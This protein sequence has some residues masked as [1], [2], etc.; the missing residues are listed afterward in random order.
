MS[1]P[2]PRKELRL[3][4]SSTFRD[5]MP[6]R[7]QLV[8]K[9]FPRIRK[10]CRARGVEFTEI[11]LRWGITEEESRSGRTI[12]ICLEEIDRCRPY[13]IGII[14]SRYGWV[15]G[16]SE[17]EKD[18]EMLKEFPWLHDFAA[19]EKSI[20]EME[21]AHGAIHDKNE[22]AF[23]YE[24]HLTDTSD[25]TDLT[26]ISDKSD[27]VSLKHRLQSSGVPYRRFNAPD[28]LGEQVFQDILAILDRDFPIRENLT[29]LEHE[30]IE[31]EAYARNRRQSYVA[32]PDYYDAFVQHVESDGPPLVLWGKSGLGKSALMAY[33]AHEYQS[34]NPGAF[35]VQHFIGAAEGSDPEDV[36]R[37][38]MMEIK[39]RYALSDAIPSDDNALR[40][41]FPVW[42]A[43]VGGKD[44]RSKMKD[45]GETDSS[46]ISHLSSFPQRL[47]LF[48]DALNQL[49]GIAPEMHWLPDFIPTNV[50]LILSTT[51]DSLPLD[52]LRKRKWNELELAPLTEAQ[53]EA[54][55]L[56]FLQRYSKSLPAEQLHRLSAD[57]KS[58]SPLFLRTV[59]EELRIFGHFSTLGEE[60]E[61]YLAS[62]D[63]REL[64]QKV[65]ARMEHDHGVDTVRDVLTAIWASRHGLSESELM[66]IT[67]MSRMAL[68]EL[69][70]A[71]E[72]HL[73]QREGYY[74]FFHNYLRE[75]VE[76]R[77]VPDEE[78][79][80]SAHSDIGEYFSTREFGE[81]RRAEEPWQWRE[82][83]ENDRLRSS[84]LEPQM[85]ALLETDHERYEAF[86]YWRT[87]ERVE[88][89]AGYIPELMNSGLSAE[90]IVE[91]FKNAIDLLVLAD[92]HYQAEEFFATGYPLVEKLEIDEEQRLWLR[93]REIL[94]LNHLGK[95]DDVIARCEEIL[96]DE[97]AMAAYP[98]LRLDLLDNLAHAHSRK[99][100]YEEAERVLRISIAE[101]EKLYGHDSNETTAPLNSLATNLIMQGRFDAAE[102]YLTML[103]ERAMERFG[104]NTPETGLAML[105][106][107]SCRY[108]AGKLESLVEELQRVEGIYNRTL[109]PK[110]YLTCVC[111]FRMATVK[112]QLND[113]ESARSIIMDVVEIMSEKYPGHVDTT[114]WAMTLGYTYYLEGDYAS[115]IPYYQQYLPRFEEVLG[116]ESPA[117]QRTYNR[118][119][120]MREKLDS[121]GT[122]ALSDAS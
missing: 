110:H 46:F 83:G 101:Y 66:E 96:R 21:F 116:T 34:Q 8:K 37:Q 10:E 71:M 107:A 19:Q 28:E 77:Y 99:G 88:I 12:R 32:N 62:A 74:S 111:L 76:L 90:T 27:L 109:G 45:E 11:D 13:F 65:L 33:L 80:K 18:A 2:A 40:E 9:V 67:G 55:A 25:P 41:E 5:L 114:N 82:A 86:G 47:V 43:K 1:S 44:E 64:F 89:D 61:N 42:L 108:A 102:A 117:V 54:I 81:R 49:T 87:F 35:V 48:I 84:L 51:S 69:M 106:L 6:E 75:A 94:I 52:Q 29:P 122:T 3:F 85:I 104:S 115:A 79:R 39:D 60:L 22:N 63:E 93:E 92:A 112:L 7:E 26:D 57:K 113:V 95:T 97:G 118:L 70:I 17:I 103:L 31:H 4:V 53:R 59:L 24:Q 14:G 38:V 58:E 36:M 23:F 98:K 50:R 100:H 73:M 20:I 68:S 105:Q 15:P 120:E 16:I 91:V 56:G 72:Y 30:R 119:K 121:A 78:T